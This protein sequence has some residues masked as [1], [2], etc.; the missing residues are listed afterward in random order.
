MKK[1][2]IDSVQS[3]DSTGNWNYFL[4][5]GAASAKLLELCKSQMEDWKSEGKPLFGRLAT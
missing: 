1:P 4:D 3:I 5:L 2:E